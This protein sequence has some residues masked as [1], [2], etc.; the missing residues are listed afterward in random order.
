VLGSDKRIKYGIIESTF[1]DFRITTHDY[2]R[3]YLGFDIKFITNYLVYRAG[4]IADF[5][6]KDARPIEFCEKIYQPILFI[7][8][9]KDK[10][11]NIKY[12]RD[13]FA[14]IPS[15][16]KKFIELENANHVNVRQEG[17]KKLFNSIKEFIDDN[18]KK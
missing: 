16:F 9:K 8:G 11:I 6:P 18:T 17:G 10:R 4:I 3:H 1:S 12:A 7:H 14:R 15:K 13:N 2:F 5:D